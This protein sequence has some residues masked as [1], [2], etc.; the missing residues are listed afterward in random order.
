MFRG[1]IW[2]L[3]CLAAL[4]KMVDHIHPFVFF[5]RPWMQGNRRVELVLINRE[6]IHLQGEPALWAE[7]SYG[8]AVRAMVRPTSL[9]GD[10]AAVL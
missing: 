4:H 8:T 10:G 5:G 7:D 3:A 2:S 9:Q 6:G 1:G